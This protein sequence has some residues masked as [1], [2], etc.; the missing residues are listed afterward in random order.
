MNTGGLTFN[1]RE[2]IPVELLHG[3][4]HQGDHGEMT[5]DDLV[6]FMHSTICFKMRKQVI[7][8]TLTHVVLPQW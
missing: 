8:L 2:R 3:G 6:D 5:P 7:V 1:N 4:N